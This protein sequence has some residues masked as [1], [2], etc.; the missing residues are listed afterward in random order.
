MYQINYGILSYPSP[1][2][3]LS[4]FFQIEIENKLTKKFV[5]VRC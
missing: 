1:E 5:A 2:P 3:F 4:G